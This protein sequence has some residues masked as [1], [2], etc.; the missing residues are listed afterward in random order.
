VRPR[1]AWVA[2]AA[3]YLAVQAVLPALVLTSPGVRRFGWQMFSTM[4][5]QPIVVRESSGGADTLKLDSLVG[6]M[7][8]ELELTRSA[9]MQVCREP[10]TLAVLIGAHQG[11]AAARYS[12]PP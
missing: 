8:G 4:P 7:R 9:A 11:H 10:G 12:C 6:Y 5:W 2:A 3:V 1:S